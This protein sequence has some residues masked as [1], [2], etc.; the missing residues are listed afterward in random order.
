MRRSRSKHVRNCRATLTRLRLARAICNRAEG[1][2]LSE[3]KRLVDAFFEEISDALAS[4]E[5]INLY[6]FGIFAVRLKKERLG[7]NP[8]TNSTARIK[9]RAVL[10]FKA[11]RTLRAAINRNRP[12]DEPDT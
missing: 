3:S 4:G 10:I 5:N 11:S 7:H 2:S 6:G 1:L 8:R 9:A 12:S